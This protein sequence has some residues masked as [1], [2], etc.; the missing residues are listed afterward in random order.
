MWER[1]TQLSR[2]WGSLRVT[3]T[4]AHGNICL[5]CVF[6]CVSGRLTAFVMKSFGGARPYIFVAPKHI[7]DARSWL[8]GHRRRDGCITSVGKLFHNEMKVTASSRSVRSSTLSKVHWLWFTL[9]SSVKPNSIHTFSLNFI[10]SEKSW[11]SEDKTSS[12]WTTVRT[13][14]VFEHPHWTHTEKKCLSPAFAGVLPGRGFVKNVV[15][16]FYLLHQSYLQSSCYVC[17]SITLLLDA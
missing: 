11:S 12:L 2:S 14:S 6:V 4:G 13:L 9:R 15:V 17:S 8:A 1:V 5:L 16:V 10:E 7:D 3:N